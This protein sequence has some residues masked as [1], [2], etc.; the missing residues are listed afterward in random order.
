M[1]SAYHRS[2]FDTKKC[3]NQDK[4]T[5]L[6]GVYSSECMILLIYLS[7]LS[8]LGLATQ[9]AASDAALGEVDPT[10]TTGQPKRQHDDETK[11]HEVTHDD[12]GVLQAAQDALEKYTGGGG[13]GSGQ[14][15]G[16][17]L[18]KPPSATLDVQWNKKTPPP[19]R[20]PISVDEQPSRQAEDITIDISGESGE[21]DRR[22]D[23]WA[24]NEED[25][26]G[27]DDGP[28]VPP[29]M[30]WQDGV[31]YV[32]YTDEYYG[33]YNNQVYQ[34]N[35][36]QRNADLLQQAEPAPW[37][38]RKW[39]PP[40]PNRPVQQA[41]LDLSGLD[42]PARKYS[43]LRE[44]M[45]HEQV[46]R[47]QQLQALR[48]EHEQATRLTEEGLESHGGYSGDAEHYG[49]QQ[50]SKWS[51]V[52]GEGHAA[53]KVTVELKGQLASYGNYS[54]PYGHVAGEVELSFLGNHLNIYFMLS[55]LDPRCEDGPDSPNTPNSC[56]WAILESTWCP[57]DGMN[58][59]PS[60][61]ARLQHNTS[62]PP[63]IHPGGDPSGLGHLWNHGVSERDPWVTGSYYAGH[64]DVSGTFA[65]QVS[66]RFGYGFR[67]T[68]HHA[69]VLH[70][71]FGNRLTCTLIPATVQL[72][73][74][75]AYPGYTG[76]L[77]PYGVVALSFAPEGRVTL[78]YELFGLDPKCNRPAVNGTVEQP[79]PNSC[80]IH[81]YEG[82]SCADPAMVGLHF[83]DLKLGADPWAFGAPYLVSDKF[84]GSGAGATTVMFG[85]TFYDSVGRA[86]V[87][88]D[89]Q[90]NP[91]S[92]SIINSPD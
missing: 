66:V 75:P 58:I 9:S 91:I 4:K 49:Y 25:E 33:P 62:Q 67:Q 39:G 15:S 38:V 44:R 3:D 40:T 56:G 14:G 8:T 24:V 68:A 28:L 18:V 76:P 16:S 12:G 34:R 43:W 89:Y 31:G 80:G 22:R 92:C 83:Y 35:A 82:L 5:N 27:Q 11:A 13:G 50:A 88:H 1:T 10:S 51:E 2:L 61:P 64:Q 84:T 69:L 74:F 32:Y 45:A 65:G 57:L 46:R 30:D 63:H 36:D 37:G 73:A 21:R 85:H 59:P 19:A 17:V 70:D 7:A 60:R 78:R 53:T 54:G 6:S 79:I 48:K 47:Q 90:G 77:L 29:I 41:P 42:S 26:I 20:I 71:Y 52:A 86:L 55:G 23:K 72:H 87:L 81:L